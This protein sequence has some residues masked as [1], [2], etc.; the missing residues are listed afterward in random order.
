TPPT[1]IPGSFGN[2]CQ[3]IIHPN[4]QPLRGKKPLLA[5]VYVLLLRTHSEETFRGH[6]MLTFMATIMYLKLN[7]CFKGHKVLTAQNAI[8]EMRNLKCKVFD[9]C[10]LVKETAKDMR[11]ICKIVGIKV[12]NKIRLP[13]KHV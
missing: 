10:L 9:H 2:F 1:T 11:E 5:A 8:I 3:K 12:P 13:I 4:L 6:I 7:Q